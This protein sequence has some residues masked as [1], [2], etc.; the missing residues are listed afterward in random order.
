MYTL[1]V[2]HICHIHI[3]E[4]HMHPIRRYRKELS[5]ILF[6]LSAAALRVNIRI[7]IQI[8]SIP[9]YGSVTQVVGEYDATQREREVLALNFPCII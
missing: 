1:K 6:S 8:Y 4:I 7:Y 2:T 5:I 3:I 9:T